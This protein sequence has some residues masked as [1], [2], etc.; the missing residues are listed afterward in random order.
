MTDEKQND[1][2]SIINEQIEQIVNDVVARRKLELNQSLI[3][4]DAKGMQET[5]AFDKKFDI[6]NRIYK[7]LVD[8]YFNQCK[9]SQDVYVSGKKTVI[10]F[11]LYGAND[12]AFRYISNLGLS[13]NENQIFALKL[14]LMASKKS[15]E[16]ESIIKTKIKRNYKTFEPKTQHL[17]NLMGF[18]PKY[19]I[20]DKLFSKRIK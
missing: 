10:E 20:I 6:K 5:I 13:K 1:E 4:L 17:I 14:T 8:I 3:H 11:L 18:K 12:E 2:T 7:D 19:N 9:L 15:A 16:R